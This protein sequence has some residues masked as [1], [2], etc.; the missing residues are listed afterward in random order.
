MDAFQRELIDLL[1]RL[2]RFARNLT[3]DPADADDL[4][5]TGLERA[6]GKRQTFTPGTRLDSWMFAIL[7]NAWVDEARAR[8]RRLRV[9]GATDDAEAVADAHAPDFDRRL[10]AT[11]V[12][13]AMAA[14]PEDQRTA[15]FLVLVEGLSYA[16][17]A[18]VIGA[19]IGTLTSR[20][21]RGR[22]A[23]MT[24]LDGLGG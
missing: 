4:V 11:A 21:V 23:L 24:Q 5:Q 22:T 16:E 9:V 12:E 19:P 13:R 20:L 7:R 10:A 15:V 1:P 2:R 18:R 6:L 3:G 14:L 17:A 8:S